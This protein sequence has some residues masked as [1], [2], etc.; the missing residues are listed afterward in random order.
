MFRLSPHV[1]VCRGERTNLSGGNSEGGETKANNV[2]PL[3]S[4]GDTQSGDA[5]VCLCVC[6]CTWKHVENIF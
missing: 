5:C 3:W 4:E 2:K 1:A 6:V